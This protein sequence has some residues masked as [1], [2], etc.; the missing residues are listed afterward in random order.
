MIM[1]NIQVLTFIIIGVCSTC[2]KSIHSF[3]KDAKLLVVNI[4]F[5]KYGVKCGDCEMFANLVL[6]M[7]LNTTTMKNIW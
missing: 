7:Y 4:R 2:Q 1:K 6:K 3:S 5:G